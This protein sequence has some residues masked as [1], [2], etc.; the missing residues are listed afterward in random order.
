MH[1]KIVPQVDARTYEQ[2]AMNIA[3]GAG[4][5]IDASKTSAEDGAIGSVGPVYELFLAFFFWLF[6]HILAV[7]W[8]AQS[9]LYVGTGFFLFRIAQRLF[10]DGGAYRRRVVPILHRYHPNAGNA[11]VRDTVPVLACPFCL[12]IHP[13]L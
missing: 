7:V 4:Y 10:P 2:I 1:F 12:F 3:S 9:L 13:I 5:L 6:G 11:H 8:F